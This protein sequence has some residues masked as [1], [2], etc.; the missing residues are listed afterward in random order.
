MKASRR[1]LLQLFASGVAVPAASIVARAEAYPSRPVHL[2]VGYPPGLTPDIVARVIAQSLSE[3]LGQPFIVDNRPGAGSNIGTELA[4]RAA[5]DGYTLLVM[6][7]ANAVNATLYD[8]LNFDILRDI[9]PIGGTFQSPLVLTVPL[10]F[11]PK[12]V[13]DLIAYAKANPGKI[14]YASAGYGTVNNVC[15]ELF[16]M[17]VGVKLVHVPYRGSYVPDL[18]SGQVQMCFA[19]IPAVIEF[20]KAGRLRALAVTSATRTDALPGIPAL[21]E[22]VPGYE[23]IVWHGLGA[24]KGTPKEIIDKL[25]GTINVMLADPKIKEQF[26]A[27]GGSSFGGSPAEFS[28]F[29]VRE[30]QKWAK[31]IKA[32]KIKLE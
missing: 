29:L 10:S 3:H 25:N 30:I 2:V 21:A 31:V 16:N 14:D 19:P 12:T 15:G 9:E 28:D 13:P 26:A 1:R 7:F 32:A 18:I 24:P 27:L 22:F 20:I 4:I 5:P 11:P 23:A 8:N 17:M 6:T